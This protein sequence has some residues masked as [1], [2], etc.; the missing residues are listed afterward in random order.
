[1]MSALKII[2]I[3]LMESETFSNQNLNSG[4]LTCILA[5]TKTLERS[6]EMNGEVFIFDPQVLEQSPTLV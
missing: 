2:A 1:M 5:Q 3:A 6:T 4:T